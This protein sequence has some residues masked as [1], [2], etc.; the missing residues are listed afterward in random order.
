MQFYEK[1]YEKLT[2]LMG[3]GLFSAGVIGF[4]S[5][6]IIAS[7]VTNHIFVAEA[8]LVLSLFVYFKSKARIQFIQMELCTEFKHLGYAEGYE[9]LEVH[10]ATEER[11]GTVIGIDPHHGRIEIANVS[12]EKIE[13]AFTEKAE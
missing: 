9:V 2:L 3:L 7:K 5:I 8:L 13:K 10:P 1:E 11:S 12:K 4:I 6:F